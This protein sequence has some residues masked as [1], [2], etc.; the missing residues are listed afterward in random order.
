MTP[1][2]RHEQARRLS[3]AYWKASRKE[4]T[5]ILNAFCL[6]TGLSRK[7]AIGLLREPPEVRVQRRRRRAMKYSDAALRVLEAIWAAA[8][9]PWSV[10]LKAMLPLWLP[11]AAKR[12]EVT[13]EIA[14]ELAAISPRTID[15][16]LRS[17]RVAARRRLYGRTKPGTLLKHQIP[18]RTERWDVD[19]PGWGEID[20]VSHSGPCAEGECAH[21]VNFTDIHSTWVETRAVLGKGQVGVLA[22]LS[23]I[24]DELPF[25]LR[26]LDSDN[27]SEFINWHVWAFCKRHT[28]Q[29]SRGRP[30]K[31]DDNAHV[32]QKNW[33]HVR[34][35]VGWERIDTKEPVE[36]L[37][38]LYRSEWRWMMNLFQPSVKLLRKERIGARVR[39]VYDTPATPLDRL[40]RGNH[41]DA[42]RLAQFV[43]LRDR[44]DPF[45]LSDLIQKKIDRVHRTAHHT[46]R[47][48]APRLSAT[49]KATTSRRVIT[50]HPLLNPPP[51][52]GGRPH[53]ETLRSD[54]Q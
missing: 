27:G 12:A 38:D 33:T 30:Y 34:R 8:D 39:R 18:V 52:G 46:T 49:A 45:A 5:T 44:L 14:A 24:Q 22:A 4:K 54:L 1:Q 6:V 10:R 3:E 42:D 51:E 48:A 40:L 7:Y 21:S 11:W 28:I 15:R 9:F 36:L 53:P 17:V 37:N 43:A 29:L 2:D 19:E 50:A 32:E 31:K 26:G 23:S 16:R 47:T 20:L 35:L 41:G 13:A 25:Q